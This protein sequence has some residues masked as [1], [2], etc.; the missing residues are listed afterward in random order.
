MNNM[1]NLP[2]IL[3]RAA[4]IGMLAVAGFFGI[5][6][7]PVQAQKGIMAPN[8][9]ATHA[10]PAVNVVVLP[11]IVVTA[12]APANNP[13][14]DK[15]WREVE[16]ADKAE[17]LPPVGLMLKAIFNTAGPA[18]IR[19]VMG[20]K[21]IP[22]EI[23]TADK[24][25]DFTINFPNHPKVPAA[26]V[27]EYKHL[28]QAWRYVRDLNQMEAMLKSKGQLSNPQM[29]S[30]TNISPR[31]AALERE[32]EMECLANTNLSDADRFV[33]RNTQVSM[34]QQGPLNEFVEAAKA[35][36]KDFP[37]KSPSYVYLRNAL[38]KMSADKARALAREIVDGPAP[39]KEKIW[40]KGILH[41]L[42]SMGTN[43]TI[44]FTALDGREVNTAKMKGCVV[45]VVFWATWCGP[46]V[47][48]TPALQAAYDKFHAQGLEIIGISLDEQ[49]DK[50]K[51][52][53]FLKSRKIP[54][55]QY[56]DG[57]ERENA[58]ALQFGID[59][60]PDLFLIDKKGVLR[61]TNARAGLEEKIS[62]LLK[63][64]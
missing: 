48:E 49:E 17:P 63:E 15:A 6:G 42:D 30:F 21:F 9:S 32:L 57:K 47:A 44:S 18:D 39:E 59:G 62:N 38:D 31:L 50:G 13:K 3:R 40:F 27:V 33:F 29:F 20:K 58:I 25:A 41:R 36:Q 5:A 23:K 10:R 24:A 7:L 11:S 37:Q 34:L 12:P 19:N 56:F 28:A 51:L 2:S 60:I 26:L 54:W 43:V 8:Q 53:K 46:C 61:D 35:L 16:R 1:K 4:F 45:L 14:A 55:P 64:P 52:E 22:E